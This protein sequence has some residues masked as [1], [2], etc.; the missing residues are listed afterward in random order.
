MSTT[1]KLKSSTVAG[2]IPAAG[3]LVSAELAINLVDQKLY[4]KDVNGAVFE[5][6]GASVGQGPTPPPNG[7]E[8]GDLWWDGDFLLVW[9][10]SDWEVVGG[11]TSVNGETGDVI[12]NLGDLNDVNLS[13]GVSTGDIITWNGSA[14]V[15]TAAPP[16]DISGSSINDLN[17]VDTVGAD[18]GDILVWNE[19]AGEWQAT[20]R[21]TVPENTSDLNNDGEN[22]TDPFI[23]EA[24]VNNILAGNN[25]DGTPNPGTAEYLQSGDNVSELVNDAGY[26]TDAGVT[27]IIAGDSIEI[28]PAEGTGEVTIDVA[29]D[30]S[31]VVIN[32]DDLDDVNVPTPD[33]GDVLAYDGSEWVSAAAPPADIS[34]SSINQL[35]DVDA[36]GANNGDMLIW[37]G[38]NWVNVPA[39]TKT[40]DL[41]NDG[42]NGADPFITEGEV[43]NILNGL[44]PD[45]T[46]N[47]GSEGYLKPGDN[48]SDLYND[49]NYITDTDTAAD[50]NKLCGED[51]DYYLNYQNFINTPDLSD[52]S[53]WVEDA[54]KLYPK[55]LS[56]NVG[57]GTDDPQAKFVI[58]K[59][60]E[61]T[62]NG[63]EFDPD[64]SQGGNRLLSYDR[65]TA[66]RTVFN[67][68]ASEFNYKQVGNVTKVKIDSTGNVGIGAS[69]PQA[70]LEIATPV[71]PSGVPSLYL[72]RL[73]NQ[74]D[75]SD[76][77]FVGNAVI[78]SED[79]LKS[80]V[81][82]D[83]FFN[84][85]IGGTDSK[86]GI[87]GSSEVMRINADGNV[88]IG[89]DAPNN[90]LSVVSGSSDQGAI[91]TNNQLQLSRSGSAGYAAYLSY[92]R[93]VGSNNYGLS[94]SALNNNINA[95]ILIAPKGGNVGIGTDNPQAELDVAGDIIVQNVKNASALAT[96]ANGKII[97][98]S[99]GVGGTNLSQGT[100]TTTTVDVNSSTGTNATLSSATTTLAGVMSSADKTKLNGIASGA[101]AN[102][103]LGYTASG[104]NA[105]KVTITNGTDATVPIATNSVAGLFTG[106]QKQKLDGLK[107]NS[108]NDSRYLRIDSGAGAQVVQSPNDVTFTGDI[109]LGAGSQI[110]SADSD[111]I[112]YLN[113]RGTIIGDSVFNGSNPTGTNRGITLT[114]NHV[115]GDLQSEVAI[116][117]AQLRETLK[118]ASG[119]TN[120]LTYYRTISNVTQNTAGNYI[121]FRSTLD[122]VNNSGTGSVW[123][124]YSSGDAA[125]FYAGPSLFGSETA[126]TTNKP[127]TTDGATIRSNGRA[128]FH[129][130]AGST[131]SATVL[132][133]NH[134]NNKNTYLDFRYS[135]TVGSNVS[136]LAGR[137][138]GTS[139]TTVNYEDTSDYRLKQNIQPLANATELVK[140]LKPSTFEYTVE[141]GLIHQGFVAHELQ[142]ICPMAVSGTK[143]ETQVV[144]TLTDLEGNS[145]ENV[146]EPA[147]M[148]AGSTFTATGTEEVY[149]G[150][151]Q[152]RLIPLLTK[153]LQEALE[154]IETLESLITS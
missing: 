17:D 135:N 87:A 74:S 93:L 22:G 80:V 131:D 119:N 66:Q 45:G 110:K 46:P 102:Q 82:A 150:V 134:S 92:G 14:W 125:N 148:P 16:A 154:R 8:T 55:T 1:I 98:G 19:S 72:N 137:V 69:S 37:D 28:T 64:N 11:V 108:Q 12:L 143:D 136:N 105:G 101:G 44:N 60:T 97:A 25:I 83:G 149:Q 67:L 36:A 142:E 113:D 153:A 123:N 124:F 75:T 23:T 7:N 138:K 51:C 48:V 133:W 86:A 145:E 77:A 27:K 18:D 78:R 112:F 104:N 79:S 140:Q 129:H 114:F 81:N 38:T 39:P 41:T 4:S 144:G 54:G 32:L 34:G 130:S 29:I 61:S 2:K 85:N 43:S 57:I 76:I 132:I 127:G 116:V 20:D 90:T 42:E 63:M 89:T 30:A 50:S 115:N 58:T 121:G 95:D 52:A 139:A 128:G 70:A 68:D 59:D 126:S 40:S 109:E 91:D 103:N 31:G 47:P 9:N 71:N 99:G 122:S 53:L 84:W 33:P 35:N 26:I 96:D 141:P 15:N 94:I 106:T 73:A 111:S 3:D 117:N 88:G 13:L 24:D 118:F 49:A 107:T 65:T 62:S 6:G 146:P 151:D 147:V 56:N 10:G 5:V 120:D 21:G 100:R 152:R